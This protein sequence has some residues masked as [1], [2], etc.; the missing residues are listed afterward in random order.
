M[1]PS[2]GTRWAFLFWTLRDPTAGSKSTGPRHLIKSK[3]LPNFL[4]ISTC[5]V[6]QRQNEM[7]KLAF[8]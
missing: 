8:W 1:A 2:L 5:W 4:W 3:L 6:T 7:A